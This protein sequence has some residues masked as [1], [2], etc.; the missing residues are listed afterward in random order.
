MFRLTHQAARFSGILKISS[1]KCISTIISWRL[2]FIL[3]YVINNLI[4]IPQNGLDKVR[5][6]ICKV[7]TVGYVGFFELTNIR[8]K[9]G[10][11]WGATN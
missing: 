1:P 6:L 4:I 5:G 10:E 9:I 7:W 2:S 11:G 3:F 8:P